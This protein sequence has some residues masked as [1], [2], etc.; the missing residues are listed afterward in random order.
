MA[1]ASAI[2]LWSPRV[3]GILTSLFVALFALDA[4]SGG[5]PLA[6]ALPD[7]LIHLIPAIVLLALVAVSFRRPWIGGAAFIGLAGAYAVMV[8]NRH[9]DWIVV[10]SGPLFVVGAL[11]LWSWLRH[12]SVHA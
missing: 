11:F 6:Q 5:K 1:T 7:F 10:I 12:P 2:W 9:G 4:F 3:L 8:G